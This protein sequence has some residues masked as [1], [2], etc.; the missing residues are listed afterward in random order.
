MSDLL[1]V[2]AALY[3]RMGLLQGLKPKVMN[4]TKFLLIAEII[5]VSIFIVAIF[6]G[7]SFFISASFAATICFLGLLL[8][9][10]IKSRQK[11]Q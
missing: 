9:L 5:T 6:T 8:G 3:S 4:N 2:L 1:S 10:R 11:K 7:N